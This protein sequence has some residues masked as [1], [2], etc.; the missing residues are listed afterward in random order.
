MEGITV[1]L[2]IDFVKDRLEFFAI[3]KDSKRPY[4]ESP[5]C[6]SRKAIEDGS[7][8]LNFF[9]EIDAF[10]KQAKTQLIG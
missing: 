8:K 9:Q 3:G 7:Y 10:C 1:D 2:R 5:D 4:K 6:L